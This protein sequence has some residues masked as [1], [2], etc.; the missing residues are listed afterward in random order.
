MT[1]TTRPTNDTPQSLY[2]NMAMDLGDEGW[3]LGFST[4][5][6]QEPRLRSMKARDLTV[7]M[8]EIRLAK[9]RFRLPADTPVRS[10]YEAGRD[11]FWIHRYLLSK[12]VVNLVVDSASIEVN[13]RKRRAKSDRLDVGKL[14]IMLMRYYGGEKKAWSVVH[15]P[16]PEE[17]DQ[18]QMHRELMTL[19]AEQ[20]HCTNQIKSLLVSQGVVLPVKKDFLTRLEEVDLWDGS[21]LPPALQARLKR[22]YE[23]YQ[24]V[25]QQI[26]LL[27]DEREEIMRTSKAPAVEQVRKLMRLKA[28]GVDSAWVFVMEFFSWRQFHNPREVGALAGLTPTPYA[29]GDSY[30]EQGISKAGNTRIRIMAVEIAWCWLRHQPD[31]ELSQWYQKRFGGGNSRARRIGI[32]ALSRKLL[33]ALWK[34]LERDELPQGASLKPA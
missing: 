12:G 1:E 7:L 29:S 19:K 31:S 9:E 30:R 23:R 18:R 13:R 4:G 33:V 3:K 15:V 24:A 21:R 6:G 17:E 25:K 11:G 10:C 16:T 27:E 28:L 26:K 5:L 2:L 32:I 8:K 20:T 22:D 14:L 34:Y